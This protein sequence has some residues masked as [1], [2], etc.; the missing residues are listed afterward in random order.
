MIDAGKRIIFFH[1][2]TGKKLRISL[3]NENRF[4]FISPKHI[5]KRHFTRKLFDRVFLSSRTPFDQKI[6]WFGYR[7]SS[8]Y[9]KFVLSKCRFTEKYW[10]GSKFI[11]SWI[12]VWIL[13]ERHWLYATILRR[14]LYVNHHYSSFNV[15]TDF[16]IFWHQKNQKNNL[17]VRRDSIHQPFGFIFGIKIP[18]RNILAFTVIRLLDNWT[19]KYQY[20][21]YFWFVRRWEYI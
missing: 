3:K 13:K 1:R 8:F 18:N 12:H 20:Q 17:L 7:K 9:R 19:M 4:C 2:R 5:T 14:K 6:V 21:S 10:K 16:T 11:Q 15:N